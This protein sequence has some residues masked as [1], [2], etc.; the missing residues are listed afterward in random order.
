MDMVVNMLSQL[1]ASGK[2]DKLQQIFLRKNYTA[3]VDF[4]SSVFYKELLKLNP[5]AKVK[6]QLQ[7]RIFC[8]T[9]GISNDHLNTKTLVTEE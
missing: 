2:N 8:N 5:K 6:Y 1:R 9:Q 4:P 3:T 7:G